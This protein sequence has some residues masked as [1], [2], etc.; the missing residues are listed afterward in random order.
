VIYSSTATY[1]LT[2]S[3]RQRRSITITVNSTNNFTIAPG[4][5]VSGV[6]G[7]ISAAP[8]LPAPDQRLRQHHQQQH[9][10][11][12]P[13]QRGNI[14]VSATQAPAAYLLAAASI[15]NIGSG[16]AQC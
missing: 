11:R 2:Q 10:H 13:P 15:L 8:T 12:Q 7:V 14:D 9:R 3:R 1:E 5:A 16:H 4:A 6:N